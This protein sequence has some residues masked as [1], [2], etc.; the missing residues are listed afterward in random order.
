MNFAQLQLLTDSNDHRK[1]SSYNY[2]I[3]ICF[4]YSY[5]IFHF[6]SGNNGIDTAKK[7]RT[8]QET[9]FGSSVNSPSP[10]AV[11]KKKEQKTMNPYDTESELSLPENWSELNQGQKLEQIIK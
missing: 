9:S 10:T 7:G 2:I 3:F 1:N 4:I 5:I 6:F 11:H 8:F